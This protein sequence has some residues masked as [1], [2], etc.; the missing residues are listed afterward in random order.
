MLLRH[1]V[2]G[3]EVAHLRSLYAVLDVRGSDVRLDTGDII[4]GGWPL[5]PYPA[6]AWDWRCQQAYRWQTPQHIN[7]LELMAFFNYLRGWS[8]EPEARFLPFCCPYFIFSSCLLC[9]C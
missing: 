4:E 5:V 7:V 9:T 6:I 1:I 8:V 2:P 3:G